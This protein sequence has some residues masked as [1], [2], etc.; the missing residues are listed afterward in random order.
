[1]DKADEK[2]LVRRLL[3]MDEKAWEQF[4][5][6]FSRPLLEFVRLCFGC[7][8]EKAEEVVQMT[9]VRCVR[10]IRTFDP[11][12][13]RLLDWLKAV[14]KNEA[15][16]VIRAERRNSVSV[17]LSSLPEHIADQILERIDRTPLPDTLAARGDIQLL[18][19]ETL[20][21]LNSRYREVLIMK[22]VNGLKVSE[23][24][25][26]LNVSEKAAESVLSRSRAAFRKVF[27]EKVRR[28]ESG[29]GEYSYE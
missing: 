21:E 19:Q 5:G 29:R 18:I 16:T 11:S 13:G 28:G 27:L 1:M 10:S 20:M 9:F 6:E 3:K 25:A 14:S 23:I 8:R 12:R 17:P 26:E 7:G 2:A 24:A 22:Y 15:H 4:C